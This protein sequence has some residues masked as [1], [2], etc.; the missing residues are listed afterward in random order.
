[1]FPILFTWGPITL[2]TYGALVA[3][4]FFLA[5][6]WAV[7]LARQNN[8]PSDF[9]A[10]L[11]WILL[12]S[13]LAGARI[14][15]ILFN[16]G[17]YASNP[18]D[19][20]KVWQGGL[21]WYGGMA[22]AA[23]VGAWWLHRREISI[24]LAADLCAP[25]VALGHALGRT[26]CFMAGCCFGRTCDLPWAVTFRHPE[27]LAPQGVPLHPS[28]LY[29]AGLNFFLFLLL[30]LLARWK[31]PAVGSGRLA[32]LYMGLYSLIRFCVEFTRGDDRGPVL[33]SLTAPQ[34]ISLAGL[35]LAFA[36][37]AVLERKD[38]GTR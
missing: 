25:G 26:G 20:L 1:M 9:I 38:R 21:V 4:G 11:A 17:Y 30:I 15:Y 7:R 8:V 14:L 37:W 18:W 16:L 19:I 6:R 23:L 31:R 3:A 13:G 34:W 22:F 28:Q 33:A 12:L 5:Y 2:H 36:A 35:L 32:L 29:E 27:S 24:P 10:D